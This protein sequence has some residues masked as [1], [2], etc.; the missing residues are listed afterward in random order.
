M[1]MYWVFLGQQFREGQSRASVYSNRM[2]RKTLHPALASKIIGTLTTGFLSL[3]WSETYSQLP[4]CLYLSSCLP[5]LLRLPNLGKWLFLC[6][7]VSIIPPAASVVPLNI[8]QHHH[9][10]L[11]RTAFCSHCRSIGKGTGGARKCPPSLALN[12]KVTFQH[13]L[14]W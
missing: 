5:L 14:A 3:G 12:F 4:R 13:S 1:N 6:S 10:W 11:G 9:P 7:S 8:A 2:K